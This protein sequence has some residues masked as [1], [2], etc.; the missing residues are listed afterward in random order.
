MKT[1]TIGGAKIVLET[2]TTRKKRKKTAISS[3]AGT[4][5]RKQKKNK[6]FRCERENVCYDCDNED[7]GMYGCGGVWGVNEEW[8]CCHCFPVC[9]GC[10]DELDCIDSY[11]ECEKQVRSDGAPAWDAQINP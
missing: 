10:G 5:G 11:C 8:V 3:P 9:L 7:S 2:A 4:V 6:C 1:A